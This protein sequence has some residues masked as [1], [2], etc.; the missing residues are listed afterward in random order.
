MAVIVRAN[1]VHPL[2]IAAVDL[3]RHVNLLRASQLRGRIGPGIYLGAARC[4]CATCTRSPNR[5]SRKV[6]ALR[7]EKDRSEKAKL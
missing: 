2:R 5:Q 4:H 1:A 6:A 7:Q 3:Q